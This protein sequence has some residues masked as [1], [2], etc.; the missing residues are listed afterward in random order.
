MMKTI[1]L[2]VFMS[3]LLV[4]GIILL[5]VYLDARGQGSTIE[6]VVE[7]PILIQTILIAETYNTNIYKFS[8]GDRVCYVTENNGLRTAAGIWC[9][10]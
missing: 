3:I 10:P 8:D 4:A 7:D 1:L 6:T 5:A 2:I 9:T